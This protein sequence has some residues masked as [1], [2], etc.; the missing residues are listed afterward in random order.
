MSCGDNR[1]PQGLKPNRFQRLTVCLKAYPDTNLA[2]S[3]D[4]RQCPIA[5]AGA[6]PEGVAGFSVALAVSLKGIYI[7]VGALG[8]ASIS[9]Y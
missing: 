3:R 7:E 1:E 2:G 5:R 4:R 6:K 9:M 8:L